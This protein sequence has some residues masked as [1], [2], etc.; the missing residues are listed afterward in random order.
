MKKKLIILIPVFIICVI[1]SYLIIA[2]RG[3]DDRAISSTDVSAAIQ[4]F[5][6]LVTNENAKD[7]GL[8][9]PDQLKTLKEGPQF[10]KYMIG[11]DDIKNYKAG[12]DVGK[13]VKELSSVEVTLV[14][15]AGKIQTSIEFDK[16]KD[17]WQATGFGATDAVRSLSNV[18]VSDSAMKT[19]MLVRIPA[20]RTNF[21]G[22]N[23]ASGL[24]F[25]VLE[26]NENLRLEKGQ[27]ISAADALSRLVVVANQYNGLPD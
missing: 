10:K 8:Q 2:Q 19:G 3:T 11:L 6:K 17:K 7:F 24:N 1:A 18:Q 13:M 14:D 23:S 12:D 15:G 21:I 26:N 16:N 9:S 25:I 27:T 20:L 5:S 22:V 4:T